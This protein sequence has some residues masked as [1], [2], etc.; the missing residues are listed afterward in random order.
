MASN[1]VIVCFLA[2]LLAGARATEDEYRLLRDM[3]ANYSSIVRPV[4]RATDTIVVRLGAAIQQI[5][6]MDEKSQVLTSNLWMRMQWTDSNFRWNPEDYGNTSVLIVPVDSIW[7]PDIVLYTNA[8]SGFSG[9]MLTSA[10]VTHEGVVYWNAPAIYQSTCKIDI[11]YFPFDEQQCHLKFGS[12]AYNGFQLDLRNRSMSGDVSS[13]IDNGEW[14]LIGMPVRNNMA[15]YQCCAEPYPDVDFTVIIR[16]R[17]LF[18][19]INPLGPCILI[20]LITTLVFIMPADAG[21]KVTLGI[22]ILLAMT[23]FLLLVAETMPPTSEVVPL[24]AQYYACVIVLV[25]LSTVMTVF[26]LWLHFRLPG[27]HRV[28]RWLKHFSF[29]VL[30]RCMFMGEE[31]IS[32]GDDDDGDGDDNEAANKDGKVG[33]GYEKSFA[34]PRHNGVS[35]VEDGGK[36]SQ[37]LVSGSAWKFESMLHDIAANLKY[38]T[39]RNREADAEDEVLNE[40][41]YVA[42]VFDRLFMWIFLISTVICT[43][44]ILCQPKTYV[45]LEDF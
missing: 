28:P 40:W 24:I 13:Y 20:S 30:A 35:A 15:F 38:M 33:N 10:T 12:W 26:V 1:W 17:A 36:K 6:D 39:A 41:K 23:V 27:T 31:L 44:A 5:I 37:E 11:T 7:R 14:T 34:T 29:S 32:M 19:M 2:G 25:S 45:S 42:V 3:F 43:L 16:R 21:E 8:D 22:T 9:M 18:H 4:E